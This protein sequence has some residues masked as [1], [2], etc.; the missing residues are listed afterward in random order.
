M[1]RLWWVCALVLA[2]AAALVATGLVPGKRLTVNVTSTKNIVVVSS[3]AGPPSTKR[4]DS[5]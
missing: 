1:I 4:F 3:R 5:E 2:I